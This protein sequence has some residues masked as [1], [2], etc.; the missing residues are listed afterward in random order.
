[1]GPSQDGNMNLDKNAAQEAERGSLL[2]DPPQPARLHSFWERRRNVE[3][4]GHESPRPSEAGVKEYY[5]T[6]GWTMGSTGAYID[7]ETAMGPTEAYRTYHSASYERLSGYMAASESLLDV[8]A[9]AVPHPAYLRLYDKFQHVVCVD[10]S[11][12][13]LTE[14]RN[15]LP[16]DK[17]D[18]ICA[19]ARALPFR[20]SV[21][22]TVLCAHVLYHLTRDA[23][24]SALAEMVG[25]VPVGGSIF[26]VYSRRV[27]ALTRLGSIVRRL[28]RHHRNPR[29]QTSPRLFYDPQSIKVPVSAVRSIARV[30]VTTWRVL[31]KRTA[32]TIRPN[33]RI[34]GP[35]LASITL[36]EDRLP[37]VLLPVVRYPLIR[38][39]RT[40]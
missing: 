29:T 13:G 9:G 7:T 26:V 10:I 39:E 27:T 36:L 15:R 4:S 33:S 11:L 22:S 8:G 28:V 24:V 19:D 16:A 32:T 3:A 35:L 38:L 37:R 21:F 40:Q 12:R 34:R 30:D 14:A 25:Q 17:A 6:V 18:F 2:D 5:E 23:Q 1:M 20:D 31:D